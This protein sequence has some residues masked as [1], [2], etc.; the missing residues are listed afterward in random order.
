MTT[1]PSGRQTVYLVLNALRRIRPVQADI[2]VCEK[3]TWA[4]VGNRRYL[5]GIKAFFTVKAAEVRKLGELR[6]LATARLP[7]PVQNLGFE[8]RHQVQLYE[9]TGKFH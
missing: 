4:K 7:Y 3:M 5:L 8:A 1:Q 2:L 9:S 6:K